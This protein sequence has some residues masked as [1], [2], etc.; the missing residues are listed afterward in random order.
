MV[1]STALHLIGDLDEPEDKRGCPP[2]QL[3]RIIAAALEDPDARVRDMA[4]LVLNEAQQRHAPRASKLPELPWSKDVQRVRAFP[5]ALISGF[6]HGVEVPAQLPDWI[7]AEILRR[8]RHRAHRKAG[9][10]VAF[11]TRSGR[12]LTDKMREAIRERAFDRQYPPAYSMDLYIRTFGLTAEARAK[13]EANL[14]GDVD[15]IRRGAYE[16]LLAHLPAAERLT[17]LGYYLD[18]AS[19]RLVT[20]RFLMPR[21][22][23]DEWD[24]CRPLLEHYARSTDSEVAAAAKHAIEQTQK[25]S[26]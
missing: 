25:H 22:T 12:A 14:A 20:K 23:A 2:E 10:G 13:L 7:E 19:L 24:A 15:W 6:W 16:T 11:W 1:R 5:L 18:D 8:L 3:A 9:E 17:Y 4:A 21:V 26:L